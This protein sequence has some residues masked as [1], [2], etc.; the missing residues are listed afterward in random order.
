MRTELEM[1]TDNCLWGG[2]MREREELGINSKLLIGSVG[3]VFVPLIKIEK[4]GGDEDSCGEG[5]RTPFCTCKCDKAI[6]LP[7]RGRT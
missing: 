2:E 5:L 6:R 7:G 4:A 1:L 3:E